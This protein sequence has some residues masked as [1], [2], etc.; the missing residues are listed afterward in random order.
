M[1]FI[2]KRSMKKWIPKNTPYCGNC[3][4]LK[5]ITTIKY[6]RKTDCKY[7]KECTEICWSNPFNS[8]YSTVF[9]C[10]YLNYTDWNQ[11]SLLWDGC[12]ECGL[13]YD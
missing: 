4:W 9:K 10:E 1:I 5:Y 12:K 8:C 7:A 3:K 11:D 6:H 2:K 13:K